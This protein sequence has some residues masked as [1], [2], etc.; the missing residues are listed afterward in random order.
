MGLHLLEIRNVGTFLIRRLLAVILPPVEYQ[1]S[2][3]KMSPA[4]D[5]EICRERRVASVL[6]KSALSNL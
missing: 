2:R 3:L 1:P 5:L 6:V 4:L